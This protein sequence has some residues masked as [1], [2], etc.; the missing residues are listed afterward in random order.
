MTTASTIDPKNLYHVV[1]TTSNIS[2]DPTSETE[3]VCIT[4]TYTSLTS[5]KAAAHSCLFDAGYEREWFSQYETDPEV[6]ESSGIRQRAGLAVLAVSPDGTTF[7]V[8]VCTT[9]DAGD[10]ASGYENGRITV[11]LYH[12]VQTNI[13]Y[14]SIRDMNIEA[15]FKTYNEARNFAS[16]VLLSEKDGITKQS[17]A[18]YVEAGPDEKDCGYGENVIV[19]AIGEHGD[20]Y[21]VAVIKSQEMESVR[22]AEAAMRIR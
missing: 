8:R 5:A 2:K 22:L 1:F 17:F 10:L 7:R 18:R 13:E 3:K 14:G 16:G 21:L 9:Q 15:T 11:D 20:N 6:F 19:H 4:G 12:V